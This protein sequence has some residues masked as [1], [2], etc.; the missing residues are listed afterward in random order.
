LTVYVN[1]SK[2]K[3]KNNKS[4]RSFVGYFIGYIDVFL[5]SQVIDLLYCRLLKSLIVVF[6]LLVV[7][8]DWL[9]RNVVVEFV[10]DRMS[11]IILVLRGRWCHIILLTVYAPTKG[12]IYDV[13]DS[14]FE[15]L[16]RVFDKFPEYHM[17]IFLEISM[18]K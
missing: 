9:F 15:E 2:N 12:K 18:P 16:E 10:S 5:F 4:N 1:K 7:F 14:L 3:N 6:N 17:K 13:K 8:F 11:Y